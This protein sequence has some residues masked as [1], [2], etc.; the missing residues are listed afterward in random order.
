MISSEDDQT[1]DSIPLP[2]FATENIKRV[3][4]YFP[5]PLQSLT[6]LL[7]IILLVFAVHDVI[8]RDFSADLGNSLISL[9]PISTTAMGGNVAFENLEAAPNPRYMSGRAVPFTDYALRE[10]LPM[11]EGE[12][13]IRN[14]VLT[15]TVQ[16]GDSVL[17]IAERFNLDGHTILWANE[18]LDNNPD[19]LRLGQTLNILPVDGVYHTVAS[20]ETVENIAKEYEVEPSAITDY[21]G[22]DLES[23]YELEAGDKL[24]VPGGV[25]PEPEPAPQRQVTEQ[26]TTTA[27]QDAQ[28]APTAPQDAQRGTGSFVWPMSGRITQRYWSAHRAI[29]IAAPI[30]TPI[31]AAD[32]GRVVTSEYNRGGYGRMIVIDHGNGYRTLYAH[33][34]A[35]FVGVGESVSRG[36]LIGHCGTT[37]WSTGPHLHLEII[38][39]GVQQNPMTY[40]P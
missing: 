26:R 9:S 4:K 11:E 40:L 39:N 5:H 31:V 17:G 12:Q 38:R 22:N 13:E 37:G 34:N 33:L 20:G 14:S 32:A 24:I 25:K 35:S 23:P 3:S 18:E 2:T 28:E 16:P 1:T 36:Q 7:F 8:P 27:P 19:F 29:D 30:G 15:Y 10:S 6:H 21:S